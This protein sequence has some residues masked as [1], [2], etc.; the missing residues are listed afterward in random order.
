MKAAITLYSMML[1]AMVLTLA[2]P[3]VPV[4]AQNPQ[5]PAEADGSW[6]PPEESGET[7]MQPGVESKSSSMYYQPP[8]PGTPPYI[9]GAYFIDQ[10]GLNRTQFGDEPFYLVAQTNSAGYFYVAEYYPAESGRMPEWLIYRYYLDHAGPWTLGP[11]YAEPSE[12]VGKHT[13]KL[14]FYSSGKWARGTA[15][16][17]YQSYY[18]P[19]PVPPVPESN[20]WGSI[21]VLIMMIL[22]GSLGITVGMLI[23][24]NPKY[25]R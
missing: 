2:L 21:Q 16:F 5:P 17:N 10:A 25:S 3:A 8:Q 13:W 18:P 1:A 14:W 19:A 15:T 6:Y 23:V 24:S 7:L 20:G 4:N 9:Q 11:F 22:A 12:P